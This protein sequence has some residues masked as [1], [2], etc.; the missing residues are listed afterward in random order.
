MG[1]LL[2]LNITMVLGGGKVLF[3]LMLV[4]FA[5]ILTLSVSGMREK[6]NT[7]SENLEGEIFLQLAQQRNNER[8]SD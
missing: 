4:S 3:S 6:F 2:S 5:G 1:K 8:S 7:N